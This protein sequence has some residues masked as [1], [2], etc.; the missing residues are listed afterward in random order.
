MTREYKRSAVETVTGFL[1]IMNVNDA[2]LKLFAY[3]S[4][5]YGGSSES[6]IFKIIN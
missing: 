6:T 5:C 2:L 1:R 4:S 3:T